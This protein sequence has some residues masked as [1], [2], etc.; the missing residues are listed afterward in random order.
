MVDFG[1][2]G[3]DIL[4][5][6]GWLI[7]EGMLR[8]PGTVG[9]AVVGEVRLRYPGTVE[10]ADLWEARLSYPGTVDLADVWTVL[11]RYPDTIDLADF[12]ERSGAHIF[13]R[14]SWMI[15]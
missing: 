1:K 4:V 5:P 15:C 8:Y 14:L 11:L 10:L 13:A 7:L 2:L 3:L 6:L 12:W 9:L